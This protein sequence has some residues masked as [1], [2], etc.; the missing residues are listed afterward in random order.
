MITIEKKC[1]DYEV[2][3]PKSYGVV[4][5][6]NLNREPADSSPAFWLVV[7]IARADI[8]SIAS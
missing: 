8:N 1:S 7:S 5:V 6:V 2:V 4:A 3:V